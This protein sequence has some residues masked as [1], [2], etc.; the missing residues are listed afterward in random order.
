M[1]IPP[2]NGGHDD[3]DESGRL[4]ESDPADPDSGRVGSLDPVDSNGVWPTLG[5]PVNETT[6]KEI[7]KPCPKRILKTGEL[8]SNGFPFRAPTE[9]ISAPQWNLAINSGGNPTRTAVDPSGLRWESH[10]VAG[11]GG[12]SHRSADPVGTPPPGCGVPVG[13]PT[14]RGVP[15]GLLPD[16]GFRWE[17][18]PVRGPP[19]GVSFGSRVPVGLPTG[20]RTT[21]GVPTCPWDHSGGPPLVREAPNGDPTGCGVPVR[22]PP[23]GCHSAHRGWPPVGKRPRWE[24]QRGTVPIGISNG[25]SLFL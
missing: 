21:V 14:G 22:T 12:T 10:W 20:P 18:P 16:N 5:R 8:G 7:L 17:L 3:D 11:P 4:G 9:Q 2:T 24:Y 15:V 25:D 1:S 23:P 6:N 19:G 13:A